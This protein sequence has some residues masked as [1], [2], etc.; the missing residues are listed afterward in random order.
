VR[1]FSGSKSERRSPAQRRGRRWPAV[2]LVATVALVSLASTVASA[3]PPPKPAKVAGAAPAPG[4]VK[5]DDLSGVERP[6]REA[7]A[8]STYFWN[9]AL[10]VPRSM[11]DL[12]FL[13]TGTAGGLLENEQI[14]P[15]TRDFFFSSSGNFGVFPT[16]FMETGMTANVGARM[17]ARA[18]HMGT[19]LR[20]GYGGPDENVV[21]GRSQL[22][23][24]V[25]LP[26]V[27]MVTGFHDR[28]TGRGF[29]GV[30]QTPESDDR[31][32]F[33]LQPGVGVYRERRER[34]ILGVGVRPVAD[35]ELFVSSSFTQRRVDDAPDSGPVAL[36]NVFAPVSIPGAFETTRI[37][38][39]EA[40]LRFDSRA[41]RAGEASGALFE[42][43]GG[44][45]RAV[46][47]DDIEYSRGG[48]RAGLFLPFFRP[49]TIVSPMITLDT[50]SAPEHAVVPFTE[51]VGQPTFRG[52]DNRRDYVSLVGSLD[53]RW[54]V[55]RFVAGRL[56]ADA[57]H[58][59]PSFKEFRLDHVR[60]ASGFGIDLHSSTTQLGRVALTLSPD[61]FFFVFALGVPAGFGDRQHRD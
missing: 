49:T 33:L 5:P 6:E 48:V 50:M 35:V 12:I 14:V 23:T 37:V 16:M 39:S 11:I 61:G 58:V 1:P 3:D 13:T 2:S 9:T 30:G 41:N 4:P 25:P 26:L 21:E 32:Q 55:S 18:D 42:G 36:S 27:L 52:F 34:A 51:L 40:A 60:W 29:L 7:G 17:I 59:Y 43:Y 20:G 45:A 28:R 44:W 53:Y 31:N 47:G 24:A 46:S 8:A 56:F 22:F 54:Y 19:T 10:W 15:R 38:Y 57:A